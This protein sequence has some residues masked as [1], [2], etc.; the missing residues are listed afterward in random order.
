MASHE[1]REYFRPGPAGVLFIVFLMEYTP[2]SKVV[3]A[4]HSLRALFVW[5]FLKMTEDRFYLERG[6]AKLF[7]R[8]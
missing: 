1:V 8:W 7:R 6:V 5:S 3:G 2:N 4:L